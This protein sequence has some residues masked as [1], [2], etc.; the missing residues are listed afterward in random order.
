MTTETVPVTINPLDAVKHAAGSDIGLRREENQDS[1]GII[2]NA[3]FKLYIVADGMGG[4]KGGG[5][6]SNLAINVLKECLEEKTDLT[7]GAIT[8]AVE[9]A[10]SEIFEKGTGDPALAGMGT[11]YVGL[12]FVG[13][14]MLIS[15]VGD[16]RAYRVRDNH[17]HQ[18]TVDHTLVMEL[19]RSGAISPEQADNHPV[20]HMLTRSLG[21]APTV[22]VDCWYCADGPARGDIYVMCSDGLYNL[23]HDHEIAQIVQDNYIDVAV[24]K[25]IKLANERGG[26]D[27][28]TVIV[29]E[30]SEEFPI[31]PDA[32]E[33][34]PP[35]ADAE[36][37]A[38]DTSVAEEPAAENTASEP[39]V[40]DNL[41]HDQEA[42]PISMSNGKHEAAAPSQNGTEKVEAPTSKPNAKSFEK[43]SPK[44]QPKVD[45]AAAKVTQD[46]IHADKAQEAAQVAQAA[47]EEATAEKQAEGSQRRISRSMLLGGA[48]FLTM[49]SF[50][51][52]F[53]GSRMMGGSGGTSGSEEVLAPVQR[54]AQIARFEAEVGSDA[55]HKSLSPALRMG[56]SELS[57]SV[58]NDHR[59]DSHDSS[60]EGTLN[61]DDA[62][63]IQRRQAVLRE[64]LADL[65]E[66]IGAF[67]KPLNSKVIDQLKDARQNR[68][69]LETAED[70]LRAQIDVA[71][72]RL[73]VWYGR[74]KRLQT[75]DPINIAT[76]VA[77]ASPSVKEK[78]EVFEL[79]TWSYLKEAEVLRYNP[80]DGAQE[81][82]VFDLARVR[83]DRQRDLAD[84]VR[85][86]IEKEV[87]DSDRAIAELTL[88][89]DKLL[90]EIENIRR[91][92]EY[93]KVLMGNDPKAKDLKRK[94]LARERDVAAAELEE[95][96]HMSPEAAARDFDR[97]S[98]AQPADEQ[99]ADTSGSDVA[100]EPQQ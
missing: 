39:T 3:G 59:V 78:K 44:L 22:D 20:S 66:K 5:I 21:P 60:H 47:A 92:E 8:S 89:R 26:T 11:T 19:L 38:A 2:E 82:K 42:A 91:N 4:V 56:F 64:L 97:R 75:T 63:R 93:A 28:V 69:L 81:K 90:V 35:A 36:A 40:D 96:N 57:P 83:K 84:E 14:R 62:S 76:E 50:V 58:P 43:K 23:V 7:E 99:L 30:I 67:E 16:S 88:K 27:N 45:A 13:T 54:Q 49:I 51:G 53:F 52:G 95:L 6:A 37:P 25:L 68:E 86:A 33:Q 85:R 71:T 100:S 15:S 41:V 61:G 29:V 55:Q 98:E 72:R 9:H 94:E 74:R 10:N 32:F 31:G 65:Q 17:I 80:S 46:K 73:A 12:G 24:Q 79:A 18:L 34:A 1:F 70:D 77:V 87:S 48:V